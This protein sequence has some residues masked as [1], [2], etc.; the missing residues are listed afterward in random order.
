[1]KNS[2]AFTNAFNTFIYIY[3]EDY[4]TGINIATIKRPKFSNCVTATNVPD[5]EWS[6]VLKQ[7]LTIETFGLL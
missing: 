4:N 5:Q 2:F 1:M 7:L 3:D 6:V